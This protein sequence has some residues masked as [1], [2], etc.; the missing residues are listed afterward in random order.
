LLLLLLLVEDKL[1]A[2]N[3][4]EVHLLVEELKE[5]LSDILAQQ[6]REVEWVV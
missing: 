4:S 5:L 1:E 6:D 2:G 3:L